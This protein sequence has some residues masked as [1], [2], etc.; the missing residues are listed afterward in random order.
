M[1]TI[2]SKILVEIKKEE[3]PV[4][5]INGLTLKMQDLSYEVGIIINSGSE[6]HSKYPSLTDGSIIYFPSG[7]GYLINK[8][9]KEYRVINVNDILVKL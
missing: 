7:C 3:A 9:G 2:G 6:V 1:E 5:K 8:D 4:E